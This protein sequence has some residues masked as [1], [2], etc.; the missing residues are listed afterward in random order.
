MEVIQDMLFLSVGNGRL[1][2]G[3]WRSLVILIAVSISQIR[4][5]LSSNG[6]GFDLGGLG[7]GTNHLF[8]LF[9]LSSAGQ[10]DRCA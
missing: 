4:L 2:F 6:S 8:K 1:G 7:I 10:W 5:V 9:S 3:M